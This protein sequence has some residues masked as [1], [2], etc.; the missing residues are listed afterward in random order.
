MGEGGVE[1][2]YKGTS[3][4]HCILGPRSPLRVSLRSRCCLLL[5]RLLA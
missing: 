1:V 5:L 2:P 4:H 3:L